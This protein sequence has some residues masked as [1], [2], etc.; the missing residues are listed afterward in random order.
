M[1]FHILG[2]TE[3]RPGVSVFLVSKPRGDRESRHSVQNTDIFFL[4]SFSPR[5]MQDK[6]LPGMSDTME[7]SHYRNNLGHY[8][9]RYRNSEMAD[10][11]PIVDFS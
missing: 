10:S 1:Y 11:E 4:K 7:I 3:M 6:W 5:I 8:R 2:G 9:Y